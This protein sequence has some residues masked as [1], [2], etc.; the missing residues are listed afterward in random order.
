MAFDTTTRNRLSKFV[1]DCRAKLTDEFTRQLTRDYGL[2]PESG[3]VADVD[4][5]QL[6]DAG[7]ET[8]Q[9]LRDTMQHYLAVS[10]AKPKDAAQEVLQRIVREQA[11]TVLNRLCALRMAECRELFI[12]SVG[13][14]IQSDGFQLFSRM[15]GTALG[16]TGDAYRCF[17][18]SVFDELAVDVP[19]LFDRFS[20]Q[21]RLFPRS[22]VLQELLNQ[23]NHPEINHLW[24][25]DETIGWI[26]QYF[27]SKEERKAMRD[28]SPAPRNSRELAVRNQF[29]TPRYVVEFLTDN[30][31]GRIWYEMRK[32][33]TTLSDD[34]QYLVRRPTEIFLDEGQEAPE[35][36]EDEESKD[37]T[38]EELLN[39]P[40]HIPHRPLK[41]PR[42]IRMLDPA[43]GSM[44]F[45]LYAFDLY[46]KIYE[47]FWD[48]LTSDSSVAIEPTDLS[49]LTEVYESRDAFLRNVPRLIIEHNI[50]G[51]DID[52][53]AVQ[54]AG[55]SLWLRA[56]RAWKSQGLS[57]KD[58]PQVERSNVVCAEPMP[59][60]KQQL[61]AFCKELHPAIAQMVTAIFEEMKLAGE[62]GSLLKIEEEV[63]SLVAKAKKQFQDNP[64][65]KKTQMQ[66]FGDAKVVKEQQ[67]E[68]DLSGITDEQF[69]EKAEEEIYQALRKYASESSEGGFRR[70]LFAGDAEKGFAFIELCR[71]R[72]ELALM[73]PPF[74]DA[75][76]PTRDYLSEEYET[77]KCDLF[78][79]FVSRWLRKL[80]T[81]GTLGAITNKTGFFLQTLE[82]WRVELATEPNTLHVA[83]D[84]GFG[85]LDSA[86][87]E[88]MAYVVRK[89]SASLAPSTFF[90]Q[91]G[92]V[93]KG[94]T[95][96]K[97]AE[98]M[99]RGELPRN[100]WL[101]HVS[102]FNPLP[103][104]PICYWVSQRFIQQFKRHDPF[105]PQHGHIYQGIATGDN[106]RFLRTRWEVPCASL[107]TTGWA[108]YVKGG[109]SHS[110]ISDF[111]LVVN[112]TSD[113]AEIKAN[114]QA[115]Y[116]SAS[117]TVKNEAVFFQAGL[118][119]TQVTVKGFFARAMPAGAIFDMK[120]PLMTFTG[121]DLQKGLGVF[122]SLP[123]RVMAKLV[124]DSRQWHPTNLMQLPYPSFGS[125]ESERLAS[126]V[127][128][129]LAETSKSMTTLETSRFFS[130]A[131]E[132][133]CPAVSSMVEE[134][135]VAVANAF[136]A[137][138]SDFRDL[139]QI[140]QVSTEDP[141]ADEDEPP[142]E[143]RG[144]TTESR[145]QY[146]VG[147]VFGRWNI[148]YAAGR[149]PPPLSSPFA[150][151]PACPPGMLQNEN[152]LP[153]QPRDV[154][155]EYP[156]RILWQGIAVADDR[157]SDDI[158]ACIRSAIAVVSGG[159]VST[160]EQEICQVLR[161][162]DLREYF[163]EGKAGGNFFSEH[164][165]RYSSSRR[166]APIYWPISTESS[167]YTLWFYY[168][169]LTDQTLY[170]AVNDFVDP[171][172]KQTLSQ[173]A[174]LQAIKNRSSA[175][176]DEL[177]KLTDLESE[178]GQFKADLLEIAAF[179]KPNLNDGVQITAAPLWKFFRHTAWRNKLKKTWEELQAGK[180][181]WAH[182]A[183]SIWPDRVVREKCTTDR[184]IAIAHDLEDQLW[185]EV[186]VTKTSKTGRETTKMEWHPK[187]LSKT[188]LDAIVEEV[189]SR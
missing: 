94:P 23:L 31:L 149:E 166:Q 75:S 136:G 163:V 134:V 176:E 98:A 29:F 41:D 20:A 27:N 9:L 123:M 6:D 170:K 63:S 26:Y 58:R 35:T 162:S 101:R 103:R 53:R 59:G 171:K 150:A 132:S 164:L 68:F 116:G 127:D 145:L 56:Q 159:D 109:T 119:Y 78:A 105:S 133:Y 117:R 25:E 71:K 92:E 62:A 188:E 173:L 21:G 12:E 147:C 112:W 169:R 177:A 113:G 122:C 43:C 22:T 141:D 66:L 111:A 125:N 114:A 51:I 70:K 48:L 104:R 148:E 36:P 138:L 172:L 106:A 30:T 131:G 189:K 118:T 15:A 76:K 34:C 7:R 137:P 50:H 32:G 46:L 8:A 28:A 64:P 54:I 73:N 18:F 14:G 69:F 152:G 128:Q 156:L 143:I 126:L 72:F 130:K 16:D 47:E 52:P 42:E 108:T 90:R 79:A 86:M 5:L 187:E 151:L 67:L 65:D 17:L 184:S 120:G 80:T 165:S 182:L 82:Q 39:Q 158:V 139:D 11:F 96:A 185:E 13:R 180:Y 154:G 3:D 84:L 60:D 81:S 107:G 183:L 91:V 157:D 33:D 115:C 175:Q 10:A 179:W 178:L 55:L 186:E 97:A 95:L 88:T 45:G 44:H 129:I 77:T 153:S 49:P 2:N 110:W 121:D 83:A 1:G 146:L 57:A 89:N 74:G 40:V 155:G 61:E 38:Q 168:H 160:V 181:D 4:G 144:D 87:V 93:E 102:E 85:V 135:D 37:L 19:V 161:V 142:D 167:S 99:R 174:D 124:T 24:A 140:L 100:T